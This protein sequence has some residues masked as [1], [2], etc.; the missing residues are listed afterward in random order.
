MTKEFKAFEKSIKKKHSFNWTPKYEEEFRTELS[1]TAFI[2]IVIQTLE[3][4]EWDIVYR[5]ETSVEAKIKN[6]RNSWTEKIVISFDYGKVK[7][8]SISLG[9]GFWDNGLN[10]KRVK[11]FIYAFKLTEKEYDK[12]SLA[13]LENQQEINN[14][15]DDYIIP[16]SLPQP[17]ISSKPRIEIPIIGGLIISLLIGYLVSLLSVKGIY[18]IGFFELIIG[19]TI[20]FIFKYIIKYSN[21]TNFKNLSSILIGMVI[22]IFVSNQ[23]FQYQLLLNENNNYPI[24]F[25]EFLKLRLEGGLT[26]KSMNTGWIG[27]VMSWIIQL[28]L[29]YIIGRIE[30]V[31]K[32][33]SYQLERVPMEVVDF[34]YYHL[35]KGKTEDQVRVEL[36]K[37]GWSESLNQDEVFESIEAIHT[38]I[39]FERLG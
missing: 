24:G 21:Y 14:N 7:I 6:K 10:S 2:P 26:I 4:L 16:E 31:K 35:F 23:F 38:S 19:L 25:F 39:E 18:I 37:M 28:V 34:A 29:T 9:D 12:T 36:S 5:D 17:V 1:K 32:L 15:W 27:L 3:K 8:K 22:I 33:T 11:L 30:I 20:G 13:K